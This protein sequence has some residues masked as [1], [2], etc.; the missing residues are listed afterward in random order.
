VEKPLHLEVWGK[1]AQVGTFF[2]AEKA[3]RHM[4]KVRKFP[5]NFQVYADAATADYSIDGQP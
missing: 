5:K 2:R 4:C 3:R 1:L